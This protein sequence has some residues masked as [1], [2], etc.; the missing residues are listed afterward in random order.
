MGKIRVA[1]NTLPLEGGHRARGMGV[2]T[3]NLIDELEK[4]PDLELI[5]FTD[6]DKLEN[7]DIVHYPFFD[8]F[9]NSL[10]FRK[11]FPTVVTVPD[12]T[13]LV[14]PQ[15]YPP[16]IKGR[17]KNRLQKLSLKS[18]KAVITL[19]ESSKKDIV[20]Y[21]GVDQKKIFPIYLSASKSFRVI[22]DPAK[23]KSIQKKYK[24]PDKFTLFVGSVN[25][26]KNLQNLT[27]ASLDAGIDIC[28]VGKN[29]EDQANLNHPERK[30]YA[31]F[32][33]DFAD[34]PMV[35]ILGYVSEEDLV[36]IYNLAQVTLLPSFYE[37]FGI[38]ILESQA[39]GTPVITSNISSMPE[40]GGPLVGGGVVY[41][42]PYSVGD[43]KKGVVRLQ[44]TGY[45]LQTIRRGFENV[46]R[47]SWE[48]CAQETVNVYQS[49]LILQ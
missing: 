8:L 39:C 4:H 23:L 43:I 30:P 3:R 49:L 44:V 35:H 47:F 7:V 18:A 38:P 25:W 6:L 2:Y 28:F 14:F 31:I 34:N 5:K 16:G 9:T 40:V 42:D 36:V 48:K 10:P 26:N 15:H 27:Q 32:L 19:S 20:K 1:I 13:P 22:K 17:L 29:F 11:K 41:V 33:K 37:G 46:K 24:L 12:V 45:R 21:L